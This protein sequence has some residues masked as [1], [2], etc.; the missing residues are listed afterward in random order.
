M[1]TVELACRNIVRNSRRSMLTL[2]AL[3]VGAIAM[4]LFRGYVAD[5]LGGLQTTTVR[6]LGHLQVIPHGF[7]EFGRGNP[8]R[9][10]IHGYEALMDAIRRDP[11]LTEMVTV[12]T[13]ELQLQG[14]VGNATGGA[15]SSYMGVG[16]DPA[17]YDALHAWNGVG[18]HI[19]AGKSVLRGDVADGGVIGV[20]LAQLLGMCDALKVAN[21]KKL[22]PLG[23]ADAAPPRG[24]AAAD[25]ALPSELA[26]LSAL[27]TPQTNDVASIDVLAATPSGAPNVVRVKV[28]Q[29]ERQS[30]RDLDALYLALPLPMAQR[31]VFGPQ[32]KAVSAVIV[33][34]KRTDMLD[35]ARVRLEAIANDLGKASGEQLDVMD[36]HDISPVYDQIE[37]SYMSVFQFIAVLMAVIA[38]FSVANAVGMSVSE[39]TGE[40][41]TLRALGF[42]QGS[43][44]ALFIAEGAL[45]GLMGSVLGTVLAVLI[46]QY[47]INAAGLSWTPPG[48]STPVPIAVNVFDS[49]TVLWGTMLGLTVIATVSAWFPAARAAKME[50][51][52]A[53]RHV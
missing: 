30:I 22:E 28:L 1:N 14:V 27:Q 34:L 44:R 46:A 16:V 40:I 33:Q 13:P 8:G 31:L 49:Q 11:V 7:L 9:F 26:N 24:E 6:N 32:E 47:A 10:S 52:E 19:P 2:M 12:V 38:L 41:G 36:F 43:I 35:A 15:S 23:K 25:Q 17:G 29:A 51:T 5:T 18:M 37:A 50:V 39:R 48:R 45:I 21:C 4:L 42:A 20:G 53:L 3:A